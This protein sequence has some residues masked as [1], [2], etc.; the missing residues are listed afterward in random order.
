MDLISA[1]TDRAHTAAV[2]AMEGRL[3]RRID[4]IRDQLLTVLAHIEAQIDFPE[5]DIAPATRTELIRQLSDNMSALQKLAETA[6]EG[7]ILRDG[8][9][10]VIV[11]R[12]NVGKSSLLNALLGEERS[13]V[14]AIPG[15]TRDTIQEYASIRGIPV[16]LTDTAG[17]RESQGKI[18]TLGVIRSHKALQLS[19]LAIHVIDASRRFMEAD[20]RVAELCRSRPSV[21]ALNK[22]DLKGK[23]ELPADLPPAR[24]VNISCRSGLGLNELIN[25]IESLA[26]MG[27][28]AANGVEVCVN[29]RQADAVRKSIVL[30]TEARDAMERALPLEAVSQTVRDA[31]LSLG[32]VTGKTATEDLLERIFGTFCIGK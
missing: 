6:R 5:E 3:S 30:L 22:S 28:G 19:D 17:L 32:E 18:E 21:R 8:L 4:A 13:I 27:N 29:E 1:K 11:G 15:T 24:T 20:R 9:T 14:T 25:H 31:L 7:K 10:V 2:H 16:R 12:P 26:L 23:L